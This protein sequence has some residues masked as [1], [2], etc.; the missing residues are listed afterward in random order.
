MSINLSNVNISLAEFQ[1]LAKGDYNAGEVRLASENKLEKMNNHVHLKFLNNKTIDHAEVIA[2]KNAFIKA[3]GDNGV[4]SERLNEIRQKLGLASSGGN[5][6]DMSKLSMK[7]LTRQQIREI[8]DANA[9]D[10][11]D[12]HIETSATIYKG[13]AM[14]SGNV[15]ARE[16]VNASLAASTR[17]LDENVEISAFQIVATCQIDY[18]SA[19]KE[20]LLDAAKKMLDALMEGCGGKPRADVQATA[21]LKQESGLTLKIPTCFSELEFSRKLEEDIMRMKQDGFSPANIGY[22]E[23]YGKLD[24]PQAR[25]E[26]FAGLPNDPGGGHKARIVAIKILND[27]GIIDHDTLNLPTQM[28]DAQAIQLAKHLDSI[29]NLSRDAIRNDPTFKALTDDSKIHKDKTFGNADVPAMRTSSF[30]DAVYTDFLMNSKDISLPSFRGLPRE[31]CEAVKQRLGNSALPDDESKPVSG[32]PLRRALNCVGDDSERRIT[33]DDARGRYIDAAL[34]QGAKRMV[35]RAIANTI[36]AQALKGISSDDVYDYVL[37]KHNGLIDQIV[38]SESPAEAEAIVKTLKQ[39]I[40]DSLEFCK[41]GNELDKLRNGIVD[42]MK[43]A[44]ATRLNADK[45]KVADNVFLD[46]VKLKDQASK[47]KASIK[48]AILDG[49]AQMKKIEEYQK[50]FDKLA[51]DFVDKVTGSLGKV[52]EQ[53]LPSKYVPRFKFWMMRC[54]FSAKIDFGE[55]RKIARSA[56]FDAIDKA[57]ADFKNKGVANN[58]QAPKKAGGLSDNKFAV[59]NA[60]SNMLGPMRADIFRAAGIPPEKV[61][62]IGTSEEY[63]PVVMF[64]MLLAQERPESIKNIM[65]FLKDKEVLTALH[66]Q[67]QSKQDYR[68][69]AYFLPI[70]N[71]PKIDPFMNDDA[72]QFNALFPV[73]GAKANI[74]DA[75]VYGNLNAERGPAIDRLVEKAKDDPDMLAVLQ[76]GNCQAA[77][78][79]IIAGNGTLRTEEEQAKRFD[80]IKGNLDELRKATAGDKQAYDAAFKQFLTLDGNAF[81]PGTITKLFEAAGKADISAIKLPPDASPKQLAEFFCNVEKTVASVVAETGGMKNLDKSSGAAD[82]DPINSLVMTKIFSRC[83]KATLQAIKTGIFSTNGQKLAAACDDIHEGDIP[84]EMRGEMRQ[85]PQRNIIATGLLASGM[86]SLGIFRMAVLNNVLDTL[87][88][89]GQ[90]LP[91]PAKPSLEEFKE[92]YNTLEQHTLANHPELF[93]LADKTI[94]QG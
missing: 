65:E 84:R 48:N 29:R 86:S 74:Y 38:G 18:V 66:E 63:E 44:L 73:D 34:A 50:D 40:L 67:G 87:G 77:K 70:S 42:N 20:L 19:D 62:T 49:K 81:P 41:L 23:D 8:I 21:T 56:N 39:D 68:M 10:M 85:K 15:T 82:I 92:I 11:T 13:G 76:H 37:S 59:I 78:R 35:M 7:P 5:W 72:P 17:S 22:A 88:E 6:G 61:Q 83:D 60:I 47:L 79:I 75:L 46:V 64:L 33:A 4:L 32:V 52:D 71:D 28:D 54:K 14:S 51:N 55:M 26:F 1:R 93:T 25:E 16:K 31:A 69:A 58:A 53:G 80:A 24:T 90:T 94:A 57:L 2:I 43:A 45:Q 36:P 27:A 91:P 30:N 9:K 12:L 3:L 89:T